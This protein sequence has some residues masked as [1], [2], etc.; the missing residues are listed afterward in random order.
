MLKKLIRKIHLW[1]G[2]TT[3]LFVFII[4]ITGCI[5]T[6]QEE[7]LD[8]T[9]SFRF[10]KKENNIVLAPSILSAKAK[11]ILPDKNLHSLKYYQENRTLEA[12]FYHAEP[13][14]YYKV[15][16][17]PTTGEV[18]HT[19]NMENG[20]FNF[21]LDGHMYLWLP[22]EIGKTV[23][24]IITIIFFTIIVSGL[25]LWL[26][27]NYYILKQ[28]IWFRWKKET[29]I[30]RKNWDL[31]VIIAWYSSAFALLFLITGMVWL[32]PQFTNFYY[33]T[34]G[35]EKS[36]VYSE[37]TS[38]ISIEKISNPLDSLFETKIKSKKNYANIEIHPP[39]T[40]SS[41]I[42]I[43]TNPSNT[44]Y[45][46]SDYSFFNQYT[47]KELPVNHI[48]NK[49]SNSNNAD[50]ILRMNYDIHVGSILGITGKIIAFLFSF[51][52]ASL[53]VTG[54]LIWFRKNKKS[55]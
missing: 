10:Y 2:L 51:L 33:K 34:L 38:K 3:G 12:V 6:F 47:L 4:A 43:V 5:Y 9:E 41:S 15:Y 36:M 30:K 48:W 22:H 42:L 8:T 24:L 23:V 53:P 14:H 55:I 7:I 39:E 16:I 11:E 28:R 35:G 45:W 50:K 18:L 17:N 46:K 25:I 44:T 37:P 54:F 29:N 19:K 52:I 20:F 32:L 26:P 27:K 13:F 21:I 31:H 40:D 1:L 49:F